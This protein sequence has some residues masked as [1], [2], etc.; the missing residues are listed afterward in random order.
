MVGNYN[1]NRDKIIKIHHSTSKDISSLIIK[2]LHR[3]CHMIKAWKKHF[4][5]SRHKKNGRISNNGALFAKIT[6]TRIQ[7]A[8]SCTLT[9]T[10]L[11]TT[12]EYLERKAKKPGIFNYYKY[13][14]FR[15]WFKQMFRGSSV[16]ESCSGVISRVLSNFD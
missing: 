9:L 12:P 1:Y 16:S 10:P 14:L 4:H 15:L 5:F 6:T 7:V 3:V 13:T 8:K 2:R 11:S